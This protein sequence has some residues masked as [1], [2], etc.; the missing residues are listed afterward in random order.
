M[1][2][3]TEV[4]RTK[5]WQFFSEFFGDEVF[6]NFKEISDRKDLEKVRQIVRG[7]FFEIIIYFGDFRLTCR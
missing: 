6:E 2:G 7:T 1:M 5:A 3:L 4:E